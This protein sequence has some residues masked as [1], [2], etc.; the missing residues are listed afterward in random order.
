MEGLSDDYLQSLTEKPK[1]NKEKRQEKETETFR[2]AVLSSMDRVHRQNVSA[3]RNEKAIAEDIK[4][5]TTHASQLLTTLCNLKEQTAMS[6]LSEI[7]EKIDGLRGQIKDIQGNIALMLD[8]M[9]SSERYKILFLLKRQKLKH[10][11]F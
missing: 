6:T 9:I 8:V 2:A 1:E 4:D 10:L 11:L 5:I 7:P 3:A